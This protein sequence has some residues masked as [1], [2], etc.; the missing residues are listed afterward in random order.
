M[1]FSGDKLLGAP[2]AGILAG[3]ADAV[4]RAKRHPLLR[5]LRMDKVG[6]AGLSATLA[7][8]ERGE[9]T[10]K[11]PASLPRTSGWIA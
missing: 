11:V 7:H 9:A 3:R 5:A 4:R 8:Y 2:Q 6:I 10:A 1:T